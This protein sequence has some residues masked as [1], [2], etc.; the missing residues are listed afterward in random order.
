LINSTHL[1]FLCA[2]RVAELH[3]AVT[4][5]GVTLEYG[6]NFTEYNE[7]VSEC[8]GTAYT[9]TPYSARQHLLT[10]KNGF[11]IVGR[12]ANQKVVHTQ[13]M[14]IIDLQDAFLGEYLSKFFPDFAPPGVELD[15]PNSVFELSPGANRM[16][17][18]VC[19]HGDA[20]LA[21]GSLYRG[22]GLN[23]LLTRLA[24]ALAYLRWNPD[25]V[26]GIVA[27]GFAYGGLPIREGYLHC[28]PDVFRWQF[29]D[30][31]SLYGFMVWN[32]RE[33]LEYVIGRPISRWL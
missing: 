23:A 29:P 20:W 11:W 4:D 17:G 3:A 12:D 5:R 24:P 27:E 19:Y 10:A 31:E 6:H 16:S 26:F 21:E 22:T 7:L 1:L 9:S 13:A 25:Y 33:D 8:R 15:L 18:T 32:S 14:K 30:E 28:D 2:Q